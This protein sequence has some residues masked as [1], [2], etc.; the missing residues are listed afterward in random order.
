MAE[1]ASAGLGAASRWQG[2]QWV[3]EGRR[4]RH[5]D[6]TADGAPH[7]LAPHQPPT[8]RHAVSSIRAVSVQKRRQYA[9]EIEQLGADGVNA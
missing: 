2:P 7:R 4:R 1:T 3:A 5:A 9:A 8:G 6:A